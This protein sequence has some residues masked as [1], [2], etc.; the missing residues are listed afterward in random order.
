[1][2]RLLLLLAMFGASL[3]PVAAVA[4]VRDVPSCQQGLGVPTLPRIQ[5]YVQDAQENGMAGVRLELVK[6]N[7]DGS[8]GGILQTETT[9][10]KGRFK[11]KRHKDQ[12][13]ALRVS[14]GERKF[15][16]LKLRQGSS[17]MMPGGGLMNF[18][19]LVESSSCISLSL[20]R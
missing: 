6:L 17:A 5:G 20:T 16:Q 11:F 1:M 12:I 2:N 13:Y 4:Q 3:F 8:A 15:E 10:E 9:D 7:P 14:S 18:V 19:L